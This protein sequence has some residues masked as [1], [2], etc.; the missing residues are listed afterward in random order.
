[1][2]RIDRVRRS[3]IAAAVTGALLAVPGAYAQN[4][5]APAPAPAP[6]TPPA[7][8]PGQPGQPPEAPKWPDFNQ[9][10]KDMVPTTGLFTLYRY[11]AEDNSKDPTRLLCQIPRALMKQDL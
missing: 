9:T 6:A 3:L 10:I 5:P 4:P 7:G 1:M 11:K 8:A 2:T